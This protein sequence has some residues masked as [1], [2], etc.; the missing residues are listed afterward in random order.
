[1]NIATSFANYLEGLGI[2]TLG[3]DLWIGEAPSSNEVPDS[4][5]WILVNGGSPIRKNSTGESTKSYQIQVFSRNRNPR[6]IADAMQLLE[7]NLNCDDCAQLEGFD[8]VDI[9]ATVFPIDTDLDD[10][11]RKVGL[12]QATLTT[13]K[14]C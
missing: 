8:T 6:I 13:Y 10:E 1:M 12:L 11:D 5:W 7:E 2:A 9:E 4:I 3:Q 14:E